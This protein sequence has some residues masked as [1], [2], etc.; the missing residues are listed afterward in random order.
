MYIL[1]TGTHPFYQK[2]DT[3]KQYTQKIK[4]TEFTFPQTFSE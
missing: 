1:M 2:G 3:N 4:D